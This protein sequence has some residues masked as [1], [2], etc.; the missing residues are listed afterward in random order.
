MAIVQKSVAMALGL[1]WWVGLG[2]VC[3]TCGAARLITACGTGDSNNMDSGGPDIT[4]G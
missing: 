1:R 3:A 4:V 2:M